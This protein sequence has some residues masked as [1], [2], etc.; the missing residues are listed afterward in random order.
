MKR[1]RLAIM[2]ILVLL[3]IF[4]AALPVSAWPMA[5]NGNGPTGGEPPGWS[6]QSPGHGGSGGNP[7]QPPYG[8]S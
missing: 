7:G 8:G 5:G 4:M 3:A 6:G 1:L 2:V